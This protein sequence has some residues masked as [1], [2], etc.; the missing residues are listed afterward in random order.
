M[1]KKQLTTEEIA[2]IA[3]DLQSSKSEKRRSAAKKA[4]KNNIVQ[5]GDELYDAYLKERGDKRTWETQTEMILALGRLGYRKALPD[6]RAI[7]DRNEP[8][9]MI[10]IAAARSCVRLSRNDS[11]DA[12]PVIESMRFGN[13]SVLSGA[14]SVLTFDDMMPSV[15]DIETIV[16]IIDAKKEEEIAIRGCGDPREYLLSAMSRWKDPVSE[17]YVRRFLTSP[18]KGLREC[19]EAAL[20]G[21][22]SRYE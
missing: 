1:A 2:L 3:A 14:M 19:A 10:T 5:L 22:K 4:G 8:H 15:A 21:K 16:G 12:A 20:N 17:A 9:D 18:A 13:F 6:L 7:I 11:T